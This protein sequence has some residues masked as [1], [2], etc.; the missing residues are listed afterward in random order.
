MKKKNLKYNLLPV[1]LLLSSAVGA[2][3]KYPAA[4][5]QPTVVYQDS[6]YIAKGGQ[7][8]S[9]V[10]GRSSET[11][12]QAAVDPKYP[13]ANF[14]PKVV[15]NDPG[16][17]HS[18]TTASTGSDV[19]NSSSIANEEVSSGAKVDSDSSS[20]YLVGLVLF[21]V[22]GFILF[23]KKTE[24]KS[25]NNSRVYSKDASGLTGVA[26]YLNRTSG[27]GVARYLE[28]QVKSA[29]SSA[30]TGVAKYMAK[31]GN[32]DQSIKSEAKTG[33]EKYMRNRG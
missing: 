12:S 15:Y 5:F 2:D 33:V 6:D 22:V 29:S 8:S 10:A 1:L 4:D 24:T 20:S 7:S 11:A 27:T 26:K 14:Q 21:A 23:N 18:A 32:T 3:Q 16:Y 17:Q 19:Q 25:E 13:A 30:V 28:K 9:N 31:Q